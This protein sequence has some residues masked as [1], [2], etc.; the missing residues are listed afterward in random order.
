MQ[1]QAITETHGSVCS[2]H[3]CTPIEGVPEPRGY[4]LIYLYEV[5]LLDEL[6]PSPIANEL[7]KSAAERLVHDRQ[8]SAFKFW[9]APSEAGV[10][11]TALAA[12][13][14]DERERAL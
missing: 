4:R 11:A 3:L 10:L 14:K 8:A 5:P 12:I 1:V 7:Y 13:R 9:P 2:C 6:L